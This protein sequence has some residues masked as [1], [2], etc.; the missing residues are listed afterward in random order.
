METT[1]GGRPGRAELALLGV[2]LALGAGL[3]LFRLDFQ[4]LWNDELSSWARSNQ[5][6]LSEVVRRAAD[7]DVHPPAHHALLFFVERYLGD[8]EWWLRFPSAIFG[9]GLILAVYLI[10]RRIYSG[11]EGVI[12]A[13]LTAVLWCPVYYSQEARMYS[14]LVLAAALAMYFWLQLADG[15]QGDREIPPW[16]WPLYASAA[17]LACYSHYFGLLVVALQFLGLVTIA[18]IH[19]RRIVGVGSTY[20]VIALGYLPWLRPTLDDLGHDSSWRGGAKLENLLDFWLFLFNRSWIPAVVAAALLLALAV[21]ALL[22]EGRGGWRRKLFSSPTFWVACWLV[23]PA[24]IVFVKSALSEPIFVNRYLIVSMPA[25]YLLLAR[26]LVR[27][28]PQPRL[29]TLA[30]SVV[31]GFALYHLVYELDYYTKVTKAQ[32]R[33][34]VE[35]VADREEQTPDSLIVGWVWRA[36]YLNYYFER[37]GSARRIEIRAGTTAELPSLLEQIDK[38]QPRHLWLISAHRT[39]EPDFLAAL[40]DSFQLLE[41]QQYRRAE[42]RLFEI[43]RPDEE[44]ELPPFTPAPA[45]REG[46]FQE[47]AGRVALEAE[48]YTGRI[49]GAGRGAGVGWEVTSGA[50]VGGGKF[51]DSQPNIGVSMG[52]RLDGARL[53]YA[54]DFQTP[55]TYYVWLR[56]LG[57]GGDDDSVHAGLNGVPASFG[58]RGIGHDGESWRW[59]SRVGGRD[60]GD[61][62]ARVE[63]GS[64]GVHYLNLWVREDGTAVDQILLRLDADVVPEGIVRTEARAAPTAPAGR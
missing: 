41:A 54:I 64:P 27:L 20:L 37:F 8:S 31:V 32:F 33:E 40:H 59:Q 5:E 36:D 14:L 51:V 13:A 18:A 62:R 10:G 19:R 28:A 9:T 49:A 60:R 34:A 38:R 42:V 52:D 39:A 15:V 45:S 56:M 55:G 12:A 26:A 11:R 6:T 17:L 30:A 23:L 21:K 63:V 7:R 3:R 44:P 43:P 58:G 53:D 57:R 48:D 50:N 47:V 25:A 24:A 1:V 16:T 35:H 46:V 29:A 4:S 61:A 22:L 2:I